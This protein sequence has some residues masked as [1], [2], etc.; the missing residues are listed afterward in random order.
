LKAKRTLVK[1]LSGKPGFV[2]AGVAQASEGHYEIVV[3]VVTK[4]ATVLADVP[5]EWEGVPVRTQVGGAP[6]KF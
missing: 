2:G 1:E 5:V 3:M 4:T 6:R